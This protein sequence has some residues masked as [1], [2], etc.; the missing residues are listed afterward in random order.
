MARAQGFY[1]F[2][3]K[4]TVSAWF[5]YT[6]VF[7]STKHKWTISIMRADLMDEAT[8]DSSVVGRTGNILRSAGLL[9]LVLM[10]CRDYLVHVNSERTIFEEVDGR[11]SCSC[12]LVK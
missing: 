10:L 9:I 6:L 3:M 2:D 12:S 7:N 8:R 1:F 5:A 11:I 4:N